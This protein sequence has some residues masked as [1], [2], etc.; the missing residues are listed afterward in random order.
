MQLIMGGTDWLKHRVDDGQTAWGGDIE[1]K[2]LEVFPAVL[3]GSADG[4]SEFIPPIQKT[5]MHRKN[6]K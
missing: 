1:K 6:K 5:L 2:D 4:V 3:V